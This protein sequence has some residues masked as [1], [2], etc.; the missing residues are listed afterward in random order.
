MIGMLL[1]AIPFSACVQMDSAIY[2]LVQNM[3][4]CSIIHC[5]T[6]K[7]SVTFHQIWWQHYEISDLAL[8]CL[9]L[10]HKKDAR[11]IWVDVTFYDEYNIS[12]VKSPIY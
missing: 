10:S 3:M 7:M 12:I 6:V 8:H 11:L 2:S 4:W 5:T 9:P 1:T